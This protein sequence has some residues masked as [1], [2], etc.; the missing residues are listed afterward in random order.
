MPE[1]GS[2]A[3]GEATGGRGGP[4]HVPGAD[5]DGD[6]VGLRL[7]RVLVLHLL[8]ELA[9]AFSFLGSEGRQSQKGLCPLHTV[10]SKHLVSLTKTEER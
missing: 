6:H 5:E 8:Q 10:L 7:L 2:R 3:R 9:E 1:A 4:T